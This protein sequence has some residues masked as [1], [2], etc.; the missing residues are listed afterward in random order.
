[1]HCTDPDHLPEIYY[2]VQRIAIDN[3][4]LHLYFNSGFL[5]F[6]NG[7][8]AKKIIRRVIDRA[9]TLKQPFRFG[10]QDMLWAFSNSSSY[11]IL[12][13]TFN[14]QPHKLCQLECGSDIALVHGHKIQQRIQAEHRLHRSLS[15]AL[16]EQEQFNRR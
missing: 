1:V 5:L 12:P 11:G 10:D 4:N 6:Q 7:E 13:A 8:S 9:A 14:C 16:S 15:K 3:K 2:Y